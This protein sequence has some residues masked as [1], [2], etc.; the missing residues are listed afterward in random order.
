MEN[1]KQQI[2]EEYRKKF[3]CK[4]IGEVCWCEVCCNVE[5]I[6]DDVVK[7]YLQEQINKLKN[8]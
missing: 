3:G 1:W 7:Q 5:K 4:N 6:I 2:F 8:G